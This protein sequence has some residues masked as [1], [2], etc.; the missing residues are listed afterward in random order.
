MPRKLPLRS[1]NRTAVTDP[2]HAVR[3]G[4]GRPSAQERFALAAKGWSSITYLPDGS[5]QGPRL[6]VEIATHPPPSPTFVQQRS[7]T[8]LTYMTQA[9]AERSPA[10]LLCSPTE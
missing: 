3:P 10:A 6:A 7:C 2:G 8:Q 1:R 9:R 4:D 5:L